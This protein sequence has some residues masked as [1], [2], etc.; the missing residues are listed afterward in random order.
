MSTVGTATM[1]T[2]RTLENERR[3][4]LILI[5]TVL[6]SHSLNQLS[7]VNLTLDQIVTE[8]CGQIDTTIDSLHDK[9][10]SRWYDRHRQV[11]K[12]NYR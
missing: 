4:M 8:G 5:E 2:F 3:D 9:L 11:Q 6:Q 7:N 1:D 10:P 12:E